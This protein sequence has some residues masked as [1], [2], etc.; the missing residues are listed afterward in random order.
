MCSLQM[1]LENDSKGTQLQQQP[2]V[3]FLNN[4]LLEQI[5]K[6]GLVPVTFA[7]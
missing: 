4:Y 1:P 5:N 2:K 7:L 6:L 3:C